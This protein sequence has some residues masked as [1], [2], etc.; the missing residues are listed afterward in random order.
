MG[1]DVQRL[2]PDCR[3]GGVPELRCETSLS[4][5]YT[6]VGIT[7]DN[8]YSVEPLRGER[9]SRRRGMQRRWGRDTRGALASSEE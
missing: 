8:F 2:Q 1:D 3:N 6:K 4:R 9:A 7:S 5:Y